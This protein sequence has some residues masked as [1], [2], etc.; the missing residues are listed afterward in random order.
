MLLLIFQCYSY[1]FFTN[2]L[3]EFGTFLK[4]F[5]TNMHKFSRAIKF[6]IIFFWNSNFQIQGSLKWRDPQVFE[7]E[8][9][10]RPQ[11]VPKYSGFGFHLHSKFEIINP[12]IVGPLDFG[13]VIP[14]TRGQ[15]QN[16]FQSWFSLSTTA[17]RIWTKICF[18][19]GLFSFHI[20]TY[21]SIRDDGTDFARPAL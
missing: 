17:S 20:P 13:S 18:H 4:K 15:I 12:K 5:D 3:S 11:K 6:F 21:F 10:F 8:F 9:S 1:R 14:F 16:L 2:P 7:N 19:A